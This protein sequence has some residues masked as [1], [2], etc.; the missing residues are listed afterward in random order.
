MNE[1]ESS[2]EEEEEKVKKRWPWSWL[3]AWLTT[4]TRAEWVP[5]GLFL[6]GVGIVYFYLPNVE[7]IS[8]EFSFRVIISASFLGIALSQPVLLAI[9]GAWSDFP[10]AWRLPLFFCSLQLMNLVLYQ[11]TIGTDYKYANKFFMA[12][13]LGLWILYSLIRSAIFFRLERKEIQT[14]RSKRFR[15][16]I[17][18]LLFL[19]TI[20]SLILMVGQVVDFP[21]VRNFEDGFMIIVTFVFTSATATPCSLLGV[22]A[23]LFPLMTS[24]D[25]RAKLSCFLFLVA[26]IIPIGGMII[27]SQ[28]R[29][30]SESIG[31]DLLVVTCILI[32]STSY[33]FLAG[34]LFRWAGYRITDAP[35]R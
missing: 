6:A 17:F 28:S 9:W 26:L 21:M 23:F 5:L 24:W 20:A 1:I 22:A 7:A 16:S 31:Y 33:L 4:W 8:D 15:F 12:G 27:D 3:S 32:G 18:Y 25:W 11:S 19:T 30:H 29:I 14:T 2:E 34:H 13:G 35:E 10:S